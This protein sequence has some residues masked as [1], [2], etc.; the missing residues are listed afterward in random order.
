MNASHLLLRVVLLVLQGVY[1]AANGNEEEATPRQQLRSTHW[2]PRHD[3]KHG[4][5]DSFDQKTGMLKRATQRRL[6]A[7]RLMLHNQTPPVRPLDGGDVYQFGVFTGGGLKGWVDALQRD[8]VAFGHV[9]GFDSFEGLPPS[10]LHKHSPHDAHLWPEGAINAADQLAPLLGS[11]AYDV[12]KLMAH[13]VRGVGAGAER[14]TLWPGFFNVSLPRLT[15]ATRHTAHGHAADGSPSTERSSV[16]S[17]SSLPGGSIPGSPPRPRPALLV[18]IDCDIYEGTVE[19]ME[20]MLRHRLLVANTLIYYDDW[21]VR[22]EGEVK[23]H[24][25]LTAKYK[26]RW[27]RLYTGS[28]WNRYLYHLTAVGSADL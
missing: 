1:A 17:I 2:D 5:K 21:R 3:D 11:D 20:W 13:I 19:A 26:L 4:G 22:H 24:L 12:H 10:D 27:R 15:R 16:D 7:L 28:S 14:T 6:D 23:A 8:N 9:W 25:E 18:D